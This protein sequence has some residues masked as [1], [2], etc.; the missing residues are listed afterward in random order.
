MHRF[1]LLALLLVSFL[2]PSLAQQ[3]APAPAGDA[4]AV[5]LHK[6][7]EDG[8]L[9]QVKT[10]LDQGAPIDGPSGKYG[11]T[12]LIA[13]AADGHLEVLNYLIQKQ[14]KLDT[15]DKE[16]STPLLHACWEDKTDCALAL[17]NAGAHVNYASNANRTPLMYASMKGNDA[18][19]AALIAHQVK[20]DANCNQGPA[21][22]WAASADKLSTLKLLSEAGAKLTLM[23]EGGA[24]DAYSILARAA[25]NNDVDMA[26]F[27]LEQ[28]VDVNTPSADGGTAIMAAA[29]YGC[30]RVLERLLDQG[31][32]IDAQ[33]NEGNT[34][35]IW[36]KGINT[37]DAL[38]KHHA[39]QE[40]KNK[41]GM[42]ALLAAAEKGSLDR[43]HA[44]VDAGANVN[45]ADPQGE[46][47]LTIAGDLGS[48]E[49]V[50]FLKTK[51]AQRTD[52]H[53]IV[54]GAPDPS[55]SP[56]QLW[57][58]AVGAYYLQVNHMNTAVLGGGAGPNSGVKTMLK[59]D[60]GISD[61][62]GLL[63]ELNELRD[64][65]HHRAYQ[66]AGAKLDAMKDEDFDKLVAD[67]PDDVTQIKALRAS[68]RKWKDRSGLAWDLC[69]SANLINGGFES[70]LIARQE[71]WDRLMANAQVAQKN[72]TSWQEFSDNFLDG[73]EIW[74]K[75]R[76]PKFDALAQLLLNPNDPNSP[77]NRSPWKTDLTATTPGN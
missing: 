69:R 67:H 38:L 32:A 50:E 34:A 16:G 22:T 30:T 63:K 44:L 41:K 5:A 19:V 45:A 20:L 47:A 51:G 24:P 27:L 36:S 23:P 7:C 21:V 70:N 53:V 54:K 37:T 61:Y 49:I 72:F 13:A 66:A 73:R 77:W 48:T 74:A 14:A 1:A 9:N 18:I 15:S 3:A 26:N 64:S 71:A 56:G 4:S 29:D 33:D 12:P 35:L 52:V 28:K 55:L 6:A 40:L 62:N 57:A 43:V 76:S 60:W 8:D 2:P 75:T 17:I 42:T 68:Y 11:F 25:G 58:L 46:T 10:L 59:R 31:A 39:N 65:G